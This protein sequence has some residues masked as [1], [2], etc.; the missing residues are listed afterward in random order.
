MRIAR[1]TIIDH[2]LM[3][4]SKFIEL[5]R[6]PKEEEEEAK[7]RKEKRSVRRK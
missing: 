2:H 6:K 5:E 7:E 4:R 3:P 1:Q